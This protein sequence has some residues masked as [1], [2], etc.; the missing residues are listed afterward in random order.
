MSIAQLKIKIQDR[1]KAVR[2]KA[3]KLMGNTVTFIFNRFI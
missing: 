1:K 3:K 2:F